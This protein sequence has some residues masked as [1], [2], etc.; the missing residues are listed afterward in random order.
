MP[1]PDITDTIELRLDPDHR[2]IDYSLSKR[3][4]GAPVGNPSMLLEQLSGKTLTDLLAMD[5]KELQATVPATDDT[6]EFLTLRH[7]AA[8]RLAVQTWI[9]E[10]EGSAGSEC[11][12]VEVS[13]DDDVMT[14]VADI[15]S[16]LV[17]ANIKAC[18]NHCGG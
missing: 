7:F 8:L 10:A 9:G 2:L 4:C 5:V 6:G 13:V 16:G 18:G 3:T 14:I 1:C 17:A 12:I 11:V 15:P